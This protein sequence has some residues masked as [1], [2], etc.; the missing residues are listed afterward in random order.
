MNPNPNWDYEGS[1]IGKH[2]RRELL[3][4][5]AAN[6]RAAQ[7]LYWCEA[8]AATTGE[9]CRLTRLRGSKFCSHH[10]KGVERDRVDAERKKRL[11]SGRMRPGVRYTP[12]QIQ[13]GL[14]TIV[15]RE[16]RRRWAKD[17]DLPGSTIELSALDQ[18]R[19]ERWLASIALELRA[20]HRTPCGFDNLLW[21]GVRKLSGKLPDER[22]AHAAKAEDRRDLKFRERR[23]HGS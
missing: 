17:R 5:R 8:I 3:I 10:C 18:R 11:L 22:A 6:M 19:I 16:T 14:R 4:A 1:P 23:N 20:V 13:R 15:I 7:R 21:L 2:Q 12:E 9:R